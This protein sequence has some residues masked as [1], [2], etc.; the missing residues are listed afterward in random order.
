M[1][2]LVVPQPGVLLFRF[3]LETGATAEYAVDV[4]RAPAVAA[5]ANNP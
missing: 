1:N 3:N 2:G 4:E 5:Q